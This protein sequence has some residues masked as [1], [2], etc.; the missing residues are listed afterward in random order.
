[1]LKHNS[2]TSALKEP[3]KL[4]FL[5]RDNIGKYSIKIKN[6]LESILSSKG[7][8]FVFSQFL[9]HGIKAL[10]LCLE[11][12]GFSNYVGNGQI[13]NQLHYAVT[14]DCI[15]RK[16]GD[17]DYFCSNNKKYF[18]ELDKLQQ[19]EDFQEKERKP[20]KYIYLDGKVGKK[21]LS[22]LV[23]EVRGEGSNNIPND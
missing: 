10:A 4:P 3:N 1:M 2:A 15:N 6:I 14:G 11:E 21:E 17:K 23:K 22:A 18:S 12:N 13:K 16:A 7:I 8:V 5:H 9:D 19:D 20:A